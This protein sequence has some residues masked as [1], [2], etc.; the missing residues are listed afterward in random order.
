VASGKV[1][2]PRA[3]LYSLFVCFFVVFGSLVIL[4]KMS[5]LMTFYLQNIYKCFLLS[6]NS[7]VGVT[8]LTSLAGSGHRACG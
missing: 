2:I 1:L 8:L 7:L 3:S 4:N 6:R 5:Q